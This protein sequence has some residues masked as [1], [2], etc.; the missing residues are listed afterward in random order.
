MRLLSLRPC[1]WRS[2][3][4]QMWWPLKPSL[5]RSFHWLHGSTSSQRTLCLLNG[6]F[7]AYF[8]CNSF[9]EY[10]P[11]PQTNVL[12][13]SFLF[14]FSTSAGREKC[15]SFPTESAYN[16]RRCTESQWAQGATGGVG[17][18][19]EGSWGTWWRWVE[20]S[21]GGDQVGG[22]SRTL[23]HPPHH[24]LAKAVQL[25][26]LPLGGS[27]TLALLCLPSCGRSPSCPPPPPPPLPRPLT[28]NADG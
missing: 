19:L 26:R 15:T 7:R 2:Y 20:G 10:G 5:S 12:F 17:R 4:C 27:D 14:F 18:V 16:S 21:G 11:M 23:P 22:C 1:L 9:D 25:P 3:S 13:F 28:A 6:L 24:H 8:I